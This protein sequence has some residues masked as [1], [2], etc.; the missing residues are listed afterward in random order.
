MERI[1]RIASR[2]AKGNLLLYNCYVMLM[3]FL[4]SVLIFCLAGASILLSLVLLKSLISALPGEDVSS[5]WWTAINFCLIALTVVVSVVNV[6]ALKRNLK[7]KW[8]FRK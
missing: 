5:N 8:R 1:G 2:M 4:F 3:A 6:V 7:V